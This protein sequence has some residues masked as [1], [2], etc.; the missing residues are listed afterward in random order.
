MPT[1]KILYKVYCLHLQYLNCFELIGKRRACQTSSRKTLPQK[2]HKHCTHQRKHM[3]CDS[4]VEHFSKV[5]WPCALGA[6]GATGALQQPPLGYSRN[7][8]WR[9]R[10]YKHS[11][12]HK[13]WKASG[14][15]TF[16]NWNHMQRD[17]AWRHLFYMFPRL[18]LQ[19]SVQTLDTKSCP[20]AGGG[21]TRLLSDPWSEPRLHAAEVTKGKWQKE[22]TGIKAY[23]DWKNDLNRTY[24]NKLFCG[25]GVL[26]G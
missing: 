26:W 12:F 14:P 2:F 19:T 3:Q 20:A 18:F 24:L 8:P 16:R 4:S 25:K 17:R 22:T 23:G 7:E 1:T 11:Y 6:A 13:T 15:T 5:S 21:E 10:S 9:N